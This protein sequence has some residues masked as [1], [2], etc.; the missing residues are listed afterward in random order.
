MHSS[1][2]PPFKGGGGGDGLS[3][4]WPKRGGFN[5]FFFVIRGGIEKRGGMV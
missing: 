1:N 5:F 2:P 4:N 3:Q